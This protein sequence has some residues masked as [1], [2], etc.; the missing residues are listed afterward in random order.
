[1]ADLSARGVGEK[2]VRRMMDQF[3]AQAHTSL[4]RRVS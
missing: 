2:D 3:L 4:R 1:V